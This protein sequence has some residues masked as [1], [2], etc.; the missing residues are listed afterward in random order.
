MNSSVLAVLKVVWELAIWRGVSALS[1]SMPSRPSATGEIQRTN[2]ASGSMKCSTP[3]LVSSQRPEG[4]LFSSPRAPRTPMTAEISAP[5]AASTVVDSFVERHD[6]ETV[7]ITPQTQNAS[8]GDVI[9]VTVTIN[10]NGTL[11]GAGNDSVQINL[12]ALDPS[13]NTIA[14]ETRT[15]DA[16]PGSTTATSPRPIT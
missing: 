2:S 14:V 8:V 16:S 12:S 11:P 7:S 3:H 10:N 6:A 15:I 13:A 4:H 5:I 1:A 9:P